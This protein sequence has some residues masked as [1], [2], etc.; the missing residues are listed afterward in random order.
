M[1]ALMPPSVAEGKARFDKTGKL[2]MQPLIAFAVSADVSYRGLQEVA[3]VK[4]ITSRFSVLMA[5]IINFGPPPY[6]P[7]SSEGDNTS[8]SAW[9]KKK[10]WSRPLAR[11][12]LSTH[13]TDPLRSSPGCYHQHVKRYLHV[14]WFA[15]DSCATK[16]GTTVKISIRTLL[17]SKTC[18]GV[19]KLKLPSYD[20]PLLL[21]TN[22]INFGK[23]RE[24]W[25]PAN[26]DLPLQSSGIQPTKLSVHNTSFYYYQLSRA[27]SFLRR[28]LLHTLFGR[29]P[30]E[31]W[32]SSKVI[33]TIH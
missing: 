8:C 26:A 19:R 16:R 25:E 7:Q 33:I 31:L 17:I 32:S 27:L 13:G 29:I 6:Q 3:P 24:T 1:P 14:K 20:C 2:Y 11:V 18:Y 23:R 4:N 10:Y 12:E 21:G 9:L 22:G 30:S 15:M 5:S 28:S